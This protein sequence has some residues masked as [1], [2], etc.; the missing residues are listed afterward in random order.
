MDSIMAELYRPLTEPQIAYV[1]KYLVE[2][3]IYIHE[4]KVCIESFIVSVKYF[5]VF[6]RK[7]P[8]YS[9]NKKGFLHG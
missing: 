7:V 2:A 5:K 6:W 4:Q 3:L 1:C 8:Q 9:I